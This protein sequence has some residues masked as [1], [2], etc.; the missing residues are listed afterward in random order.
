[1]KRIASPKMRHVR[2]LSPYNRE[3]AGAT[4]IGGKSFLSNYA[5]TGGG[6]LMKGGG[7]K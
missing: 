1:M 3:N 7:D 2:A 5:G 6:G 4:Q